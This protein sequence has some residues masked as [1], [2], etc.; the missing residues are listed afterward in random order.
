MAQNP[1]FISDADFCDKTVS[2]CVNPGENPFR[3]ASS[4]ITIVET[5]ASPESPQANENVKVRL[6]DTLKNL[7]EMLFDL[8]DATM[9]HYV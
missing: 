6:V 2:Y 8:N 5:P 3:T 4:N 7:H 9:L 1:A